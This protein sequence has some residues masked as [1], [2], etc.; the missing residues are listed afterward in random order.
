MSQ[1]VD[2]PLLLFQVATY[3]LAWPQ[4]NII[5]ILATDS[6]SLTVFFLVESRIERYEKILLRAVSA[7]V[8]AVEDAA[9]D[10]NPGSFSDMR[11]GGR[12]NKPLPANIPAIMEHLSRGM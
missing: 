11:L 2:S 3:C 10:R 4:P 6:L 8:L 1:A 5:Y 7:M 12:L 9:E